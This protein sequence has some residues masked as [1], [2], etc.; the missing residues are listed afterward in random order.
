[1]FFVNCVIINITEYIKNNKALIPVFFS[2]ILT[3]EVF[4]HFFSEG[5]RPG[6]GAEGDITGFI[7]PIFIVISASVLAFSLSQDNRK[8]IRIHVYNMIIELLSI[9]FGMA[10]TFFLPSR[11]HRYFWPRDFMPLLTLCF[12]YFLPF[13]ICYLLFCGLGRISWIRERII[14]KAF[15]TL[16]FL[17]LAYGPLLIVFMRLAWL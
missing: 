1:M 3:Y 17:I 15:V 16:L 10:A 9:F 7:A 6:A 4:D 14:L 12:A 8:M 5:M 11:H 2:G 13:L